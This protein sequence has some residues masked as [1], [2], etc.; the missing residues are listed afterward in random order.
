MIRAL[1]HPLLHFVLLGGALFGARAS[2][3]PAWEPAARPR[4]AVA[5]EDI[6]RARDEWAA[7]NG[8]PPDPRTDATLIDQLIDE[9]VL[10]REALAAGLDRRDT[11]ARTRLADLQRFLG[12]SA[13]H[14]G[15]PGTG[16]EAQDVVIRRHLVSLM[17]LA[18]SRPDIADAPDDTAL[19][20]FLA[21]RAAEFAEPPRWR[22]TH[23]YLSRDRRGPALEHD[24]R[25]LLERLRR[26]RVEPAT[27]GDVG[28]PFLHGAYLD[29]MAAGDLDR[30]FGSG[31]AAALTDAPLAQWIGPVRSS[32]GLHLVWVHER[33]A[34][35]MPAVEAVRAQLTHRLLDARGRARLRERLDLLRAR[36]EVVVER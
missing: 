5:A 2:G 7:S 26:T 23:V 27:S 25:A 15:D 14:A 18:L 10:L 20:R 3:G 34:G 36:Y 33:T 32:Y 1:R 8:G 4:L 11:L 17:R 24:A 13:E 19:A 12:E 30:L 35:R 22:L 29:G 21:D 6:R 9:Q 31:F 16:L 28:E